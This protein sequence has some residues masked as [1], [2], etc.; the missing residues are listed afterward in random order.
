MMADH[1][2]MAS[3]DGEGFDRRG[4]LKRRVGVACCLGVVLVLGVA[5]RRSPAQNSMELTRWKEFSYAK[6][7]K[8]VGGRMASLN[9]IHRTGF[10]VLGD[11]QFA[12]LSGWVVHT[13]IPEGKEYYQGFLMYDFQDG[14]SILAKVDASGV[15]N[16]KQ[17]GTIVFV[18]GTKRYEGIT[19]RGTISSWMPR[20]WDMYTEIEASFSVTGD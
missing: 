4:G 14:S 5:S 16:A 8:P 3:V 13:A 17:V 18:A 15:L 12:R 1:K 9:A 20:P 6:E 7:I 2:V 19:G 11:G 10:V